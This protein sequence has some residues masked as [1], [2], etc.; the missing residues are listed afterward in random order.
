MVI[1]SLR[2]LCLRVTLLQA[3]PMTMGQ[4]PT[5]HPHPQ[6][7][8]SH[9]Q[10]GAIGLGDPVALPVFTFEELSERPEAREGRS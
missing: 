1:L 7:L 6:H 5:S 3:C 8:L 2:L 10:S 4:L 9:L